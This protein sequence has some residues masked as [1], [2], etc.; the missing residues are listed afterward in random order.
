[1]QKIETL[2]SR[3]TLS[4]TVHESRVATCGRPGNECKTT[5]NL[6]MNKS[7]LTFW[8]FQ[9]IDTLTGWGCNSRAKHMSQS[10]I[11]F[12]LEILYQPHCISQSGCRLPIGNSYSVSGTPIDHE[13]SCHRAC[14]CH[15]AMIEKRCGRQPGQLAKTELY[16]L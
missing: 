4:K 14:T 7:Y 1:M 16:K 12:Q 5:N 15:P 13:A 6:Y 10:K 8:C 2:K 3:A 11:R 9:D